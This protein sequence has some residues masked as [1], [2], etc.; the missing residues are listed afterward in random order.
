MS[1]PQVG[2]QHGRQRY[3]RLA[4]DSAVEVILSPTA[5]ARPKAAARQCAA[6]S[7]VTVTPAPDFVVLDATDAPRAMLE[8][9]STNNGGT[10]RDKATRIRRSGGPSRGRA[11][12]ALG[13]RA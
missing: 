8:C 6:G 4:R 9:K 12:G 1:V 3:A 5:T 7:V 13:R 10:G 2:D 11:P